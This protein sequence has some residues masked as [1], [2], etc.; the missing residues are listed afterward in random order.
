MVL[1]AVPPVGATGVLA[2]SYGWGAIPL[3]VAYRAGTGGGDGQL[4]LPVLPWNR[5]VDGN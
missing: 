1:T 3:M 5:L 4:P 2:T